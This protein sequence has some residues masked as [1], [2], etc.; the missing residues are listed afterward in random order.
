MRRT[1]LLLVLASLV[2]NAQAAKVTPLMSK[3]LKECPGKEG[4]LILV[5]YPQAAP[6]ESTA[7]MRTHLFT[8]RKVPW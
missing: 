3:E 8:S 2:V 6:I 4:L 1:M 7:T 5:Q